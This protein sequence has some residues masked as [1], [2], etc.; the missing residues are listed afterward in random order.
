[1]TFWQWVIT[2]LLLLWVVLPVSAH[3]IAFSITT[4]T[5][6]ARVKWASRTQKVL[7]KAKKYADERTKWP[8]N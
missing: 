6:N 2:V 5:L 3:M 8:A 4:A 1:M 7:E